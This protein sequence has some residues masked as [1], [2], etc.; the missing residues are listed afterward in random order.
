MRWKKKLAVATNSALTRTCRPVTVA[1]FDVM[2]RRAVR[3]AALRPAA[4]R[5]FPVDP[6]GLQ[7]FY[8]KSH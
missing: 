1:A 5:T 6:S 8:G 7:G 2:S 3:L 4:V